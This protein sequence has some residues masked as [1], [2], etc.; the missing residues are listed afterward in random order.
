MGIADEGK[1]IVGDA[2]KN[3]SFTSSNT[4]GSETEAQR[5]FKRSIDELFAVDRWS[6]LP[7]ISSRFEL[8][9]ENGERKNAARPAIGDHIKIILPGVPV[10]NWV[11]VTDLKQSEASAEF[12]VSPCNDPKASG[13]ERKQIKHFFADFFGTKNY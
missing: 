1:F 7:G 11:A 4:F 12:T 6:D 2:K 13:E 5:E 9:D 3:V 8:H 10:D